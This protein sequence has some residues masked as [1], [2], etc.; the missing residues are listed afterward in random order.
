M[1]FIILSF[2]VLYIMTDLMLKSTDSPD[3]ATTTIFVVRK[4]SQ[5]PTL[6]NLP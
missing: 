3:P 1:C 6:P 4:I 2:D 5:T